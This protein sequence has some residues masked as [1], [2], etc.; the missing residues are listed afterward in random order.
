VYTL[1]DVGE[2]LNKAFALAGPDDLVCVTGSLYMVAEARELLLK[3][4]HR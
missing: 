4:R 2:A 3:N 1:E